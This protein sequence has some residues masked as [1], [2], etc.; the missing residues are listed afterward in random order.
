MTHH[1]G[2]SRDRGG[3]GDGC[4]VSVAI[5]AVLSLRCRPAL[6]LVS[7]PP[8][9][10]ALVGIAAGPRPFVPA[11]VGFVAGPPHF[12]PAL[13]G[14]GAVAGRAAATLVRPSL[15]LPPPLVP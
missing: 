7:G 11:L 6:R 10:A 14:F 5:S 2:A 9:V 12:V 3:A 13:V 1:W 15:L 8:R 4:S